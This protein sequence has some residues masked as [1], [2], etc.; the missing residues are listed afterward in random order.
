[1]R[2]RTLGWLF[3]CLSALCLLGMGGCSTPGSRIAD[4]TTLFES[5]PPEVQENI[6]NGNVE[7]GYTP[8]MVEMALGKPDR[9]AHTGGEYGDLEVWTYEKKTPGIGFGV[10]SGRSIGSS[11]GIGTG[12]SVGQPATTRE[13]AVVEFRDGQVSGFRTPARE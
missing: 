8:A 3:L 10:G 1:M 5:F 9:K 7:L 11:V 12:V 6:R 4:D 13:E 2:S